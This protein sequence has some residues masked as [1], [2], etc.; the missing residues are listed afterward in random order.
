MV[1]NGKY[2]VPFQLVQL[3]ID[4]SSGHTDTL[5]VHLNLS[6]FKLFRNDFWSS[7][8]Q[9][10]Y[11]CR[12]LHILEWLFSLHYLFIFASFHS[13][14][15]LSSFMC[16]DFLTEISHLWGGALLPLGPPNVWICY[17]S[18]LPSFSFLLKI[19]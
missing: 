3:K 14:I 4:R 1:D 13:E 12:W 17:Y 18:F 8:F 15:I 7:N 16:F 5:L 2:I 11:L 9:M 6:L 10:H 19:F